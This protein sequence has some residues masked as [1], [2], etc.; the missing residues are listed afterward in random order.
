MQG[1]RVLRSTFAVFVRGGKRC[2]RT[3][4][5]VTPSVAA[6]ECTGYTLTY[7]AYEIDE[8]TMEKLLTP[9]EISERLGVKLSTIYQWTHIGYIPHF[10]LGRFVRFKERDILAWLESKRINGRLTRTIDLEL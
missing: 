8:L 2:S 5:S 7:G 9:E 10:K 6:G 1:K 3:G 4:A